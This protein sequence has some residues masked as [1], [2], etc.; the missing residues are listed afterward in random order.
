MADTVAHYVPE[1][2][3]FMAELPTMNQLVDNG[4]KFRTRMIDQQATFVR[5]LMKAMHPMTMRFDAVKPA[6]KATPKAAP[7]ATVKAAP[8]RVVKAA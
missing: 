2:P 3:T 7:K 5:Q 4:L 1:R 6:P 8:R